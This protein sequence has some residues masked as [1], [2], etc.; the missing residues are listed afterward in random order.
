MIGHGASE[1]GLD[2]LTSFYPQSAVSARVFMAA[3]QI[4][5]LLESLHQAMRQLSNQ[6]NPPRPPQKNPIDLPDDD[7]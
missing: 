6:R 5:R 7:F 1:F 4:P 3:G 2:F